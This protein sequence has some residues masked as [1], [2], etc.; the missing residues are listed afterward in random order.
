MTFPHVRKIQSGKRGVLNAVLPL[1]D[2]I[3]EFKDHYNVKYYHKGFLSKNDN[4]N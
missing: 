3:V 2:S 4:K 1:F